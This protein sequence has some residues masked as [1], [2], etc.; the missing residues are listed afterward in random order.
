MKKQILIILTAIAAATS[1]AAADAGKLTFVTG[2]V[3]VNS[4]K[5]WQ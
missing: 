1:L 3:E 4:G 5:G 2:S